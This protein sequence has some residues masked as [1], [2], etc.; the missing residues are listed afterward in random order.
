MG[1]EEEPF[2][3]DEDEDAGYVTALAVVSRDRC[4][5]ALHR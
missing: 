2:A 5:F 3:D 1:Y 4:A